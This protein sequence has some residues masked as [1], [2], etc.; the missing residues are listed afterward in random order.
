MQVAKHNFSDGCLHFGSLPHC[1]FRLHISRAM[2]SQ[3]CSIITSD[4]ITEIKMSF[5]YH[6]PNMG[7]WFIPCGLMNF[8]ANL[9][10]IVSQL[11]LF[12]GFLQ[13]FDTVVWVTGR[14][15]WSVKSM[16]QHSHKV[17]L[18]KIWGARWVIFGT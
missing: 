3:R 14:I 5:S 13:G 16:H 10:D 7:N 12:F 2:I 8:V 17:I 9:I 11:C 6:L 15:F 18:W 1:D 4:L